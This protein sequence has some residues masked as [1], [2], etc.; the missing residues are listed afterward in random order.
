MKARFLLL[1]AL[2]VSLMTG[3]DG[4][5]PPAELERVQRCIEDA[6]GRAE[7]SVLKDAKH[8]NIGHFIDKEEFWQWLEVAACE[9]A[10]VPQ[11]D[12]RGQK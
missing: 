10:T 8:D 6:G 3:S 12:G 1:F 5:T 2:G 7:F 9:V 11:V 4:V